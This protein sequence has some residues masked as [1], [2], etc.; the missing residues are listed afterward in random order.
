MVRLLRHEYGRASN[1]ACKQG[2]DDKR[3]G[4]KTAGVAHG[5]GNLR[6]N[7]ERGQNITLQ[8]AEE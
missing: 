3:K 6:G 5:H 1:D 2:G 7:I 4:G 8:L